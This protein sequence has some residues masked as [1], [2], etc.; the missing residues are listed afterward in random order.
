MGQFTFDERDAAICAERAA[1]IL[2][3]PHPVVGDFVVFADGVTRRVS[4]NWGDAV[5]TSD[6]GS[7]YLYNGGGDFSGAL[8]TSVPVDTLTKTEETRPGRVWIFHHNYTCA[9]GAV[10]TEVPFKVWTCSL[11]APT[12]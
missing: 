12:Y 1:P 10:H 2:T 5:Q 8:F 4:Y 9:G 6:H 7:F 11:P 3:N